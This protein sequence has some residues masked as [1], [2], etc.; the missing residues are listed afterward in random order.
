[1]ASQ[2]DTRPIEKFQISVFRFLQVLHI[3]SFTK[4]IHL[5][6]IPRRGECGGYALNRWYGV[7]FDISFM[8]DVEHVSQN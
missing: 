2:S 4:N 3:R 5:P 8:R 6:L 7:K 1:M